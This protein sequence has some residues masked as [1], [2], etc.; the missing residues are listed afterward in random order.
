MKGSPYPRY[1]SYATA[2]VSVLC[3]NAMVRGQEKTVENRL[4]DK[5]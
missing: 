3:S 2:I 1:V 5:L 4:I